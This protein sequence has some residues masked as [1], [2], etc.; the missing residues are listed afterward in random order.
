MSAKLLAVLVSA[1]LGL[2]CQVAPR[3]GTGDG[4]AGN[5][6]EAAAGADQQAPDAATQRPEAAADRAGAA[7]QAPKAAPAREPARAAAA[8]TAEPAPAKQEPAPIVVPAG[9]G[10][11]LELA[12]AVS[13]ATSRQGDLVVA[14]LVSPVKVGERVVLAEGT[15]VRGRVTAAVPS[16]RVKGKARLALAFENVVVAG[17]ERPIAASGLDVTADS[18]KKR[19]AAVI[20][21][22]A[23]AGAI[24]G[25]IA[26]GGK[27]AAVGAVIG[28]AAGTGA[29]LATKGNEVELPAGTAIDSRLEADLRLSGS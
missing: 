7:S 14:R 9:T 24:I 6:E 19:D 22:A 20:G 1:A 17:R 11:R 26:K 23:G 5:P 8:P 12:S 16:G 3:Q 10:L 13:S 15:E 25:G 18:S 27:G 2:G 4:S 21:G 28:G 29:V